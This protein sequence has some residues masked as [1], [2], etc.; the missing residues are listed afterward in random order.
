MKQ[1]V[2]NILKTI[3][4]IPTVVKT[5]TDKEKTEFF[6]NLR[7]RSIAV[8][9]HI[10]FDL[11]SE[12]WNKHT[13]ADNPRKLKRKQEVWRRSVRTRRSPQRLI[14]EGKLR[15]NRKRRKPSRFSPQPFH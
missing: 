7:A 15:S 4:T 13:G 14:N 12:A 2:K 1:T 5:L 11:A 3:D 9:V 6:A 8:D 10:D